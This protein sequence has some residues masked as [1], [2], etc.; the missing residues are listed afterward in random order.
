MS[1]IAIAYQLCEMTLTSSNPIHK[2]PT[3]IASTDQKS[4]GKVRMRVAA[5]CAMI[6][7]GLAN[8][9]CPFFASFLW[10][11]KEMK[12]PTAGIEAE[13]FILTTANV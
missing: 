10:A 11:N 7:L 2:A 13:Q 9:D 1:N 6:A 4:G 8:T 5:F 3:E 12:M